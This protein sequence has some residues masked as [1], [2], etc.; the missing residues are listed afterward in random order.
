MKT[1]A[2]FTERVSRRKLCYF[3]LSFI[4]G[5]EGIGSDEELRD[6]DD[7]DDLEVRE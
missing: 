4:E 6:H 2:R 1:A 3:L 5:L 7:V